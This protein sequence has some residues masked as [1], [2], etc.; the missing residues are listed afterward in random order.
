[1][2]K[3]IYSA[4]GDFM[5][6]G[7]GA[8]A[9]QAVSILLIPVYTRWLGVADYGVLSLLMGIQF[10]LVPLAQAGMGSALFRSYYDYNDEAGHRGVI[11]T[12]FWLLLPAS[13]G[14][15]AIAYLL[16]GVAA[17]QLARD[18]IE[19]RHLQ[20]IALITFAEGLGILPFSVFRARRQAVR[21]MTTTI[22]TLLVRLGAIIWM[23]VVLRSGL[24]GVLHGMFIGAVAGVAG[25]YLQLGRTLTWMFN[26]GDAARLLRFGLPLIPINVAFWV[27]AVS[28]RYI[29]ARHVTM[30]QVGLYALAERLANVLNVVLVQPLGLLWLPV[31][32]SV[33]RQEHARRFYSRMFSYF[34]MAGV[35]A[36]LCLALVVPEVLPLLA[37]P[38]F[39][40]AAPFVFPLCLGFVAFGA[41]RILNVGTDLARTPERYLVALTI[42]CAVFLVG[43]SLLIPRWAVWG[44]VG[45]TIAA[46]TLFSGLVFWFGNQQYRVRFDWTRVAVIVAAGVLCY[47][48][49]QA[50][51][52]LVAAAGWRWGIKLAAA[53]AYP[54]ILLASGVVQPEE[55]AELA[56]QWA[57][58][59]ARMRG[60]PDVAE[61]NAP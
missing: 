51:S 32:L 11:N 4:F 27:L 17:G 50:G 47:V 15:G 40:P 59:R 61:R 37:P 7:L 29:L 1:M 5:I 22:L 54:V 45:V 52:G 57:A 24:M 34:M 38:S 36:S 41:S 18:A 28:G 43:C 30:E 56:R 3:D 10:M 8:V 31:M 48:L 35:F 2:R 53:V 19:V 49:A 14:V 33:S 58:L 26:R 39:F 46:S 55:R 9:M 12:A 16:A 60:G 25:G 42:A 23:V 21:F 20:W 6:Y 13:L 44:L